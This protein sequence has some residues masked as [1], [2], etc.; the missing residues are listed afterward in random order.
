MGKAKIK[1]EKL[2]ELLEM[3]YMGII[4]GAIK[5][6]KKIEDPENF[7]MPF[8][9]ASIKLIQKEV[10]YLIVILEMLETLKNNKK[11]EVS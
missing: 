9:K 8:R 3:H 7:V 4:N 11:V 6:L 10:G 5:E 1:K 2:I